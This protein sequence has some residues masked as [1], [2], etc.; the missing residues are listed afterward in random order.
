MYRY[1]T[2]LC[3]S[4]KCIRQC[5]KTTKKSLILQLGWGILAISCEIVNKRCKMRHFWWFSNTI[6]TLLQTSI[7]MSETIT[8][9]CDHHKEKYS[10]TK[11][12]LPVSPH[13][14]LHPNTHDNIHLKDYY[15]YS[16]LKSHDFLPVLISTLWKLNR[17]QNMMNLLNLSNL[18][19]E[20]S[21]HE[22]LKPSS[23][24]HSTLIRLRLFLSF[25]KN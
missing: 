7:W 5:L 2:E 20:K 3:C 6:H 8:K 16:S 22:W 15:L 17:N 10:T 13:L 1:T 25:S 14:C 12:H 9:V 19:F 11:N 23:S 18:M 24:I 21:R 4:F